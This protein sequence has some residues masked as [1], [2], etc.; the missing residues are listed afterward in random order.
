[1]LTLTETPNVCFLGKPLTYEPKGPPQYVPLPQYGISRAQIK[2]SLKSEA[3][4][5][6]PPF[7]RIQGDYLLL[8]GSQ[9]PSAKD[10]HLIL[11]A[12]DP[13]S[14]SCDKL[15]LHITSNIYE[16]VLERVPFCS[17]VVFNLGDEIMLPIPIY[18]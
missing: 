4:T 6:I 13:V 1:M 5:P 12:C 7:V 3:G 10:Y 15:A 18:K 11:Q 17:P 14:E 16:I 9:N 8:E 2:F